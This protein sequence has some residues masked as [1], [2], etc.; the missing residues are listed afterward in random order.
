MSK[1]TPGTWHAMDDIGGSISVQSE[2]PKSNGGVA[3]AVCY[4]PNREANARLIAAAPDLLATLQA[5]DN[6]ITHSHARH[7]PMSLVEQARA[8]IKRA[9]EG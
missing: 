1:H 9:T 5:W 7:I 2:I 3:D 8:A 4:G 6:W